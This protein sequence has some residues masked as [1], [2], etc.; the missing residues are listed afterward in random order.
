MVVLVF[1]T[2][3]LRFH[4]AYHQILRSIGLVE[5]LLLLFRTQTSCLSSEAIASTRI[6][7][8]YPTSTMKLGTINYAK[9]EY[10]AVNESNLMAFLSSH[11][12]QLPVV[13]KQDSV[14]SVLSG[15]E[16]VVL[17]D[18]LALFAEAA[19]REMSSEDEDFYTRTF[20]SVPTLECVCI[21]LTDGSFQDHAVRL[22]EMTLRVALSFKRQNTSIYNAI[23]CIMQSIRY[24]ALSIYCRGDN[25]VTLA[26]PASRKVLRVALGCLDEVVRPVQVRR[27]VLLGRDVDN[28]RLGD[29]HKSDRDQIHVALSDCGG[30]YTCLAAL[31]ALANSDATDLNEQELN[32]HDSFFAVCFIMRLIHAQIASSQLVQQAFS[33]YVTMYRVFFSQ[34]SRVNLYFLHPARTVTFGLYGDLLNRFL[35]SRFGNPSS[36]EKESRHSSECLV[37]CI[38]S[39]LSLA[40][41]DLSVETSVDFGVSA[42]E[43]PH[44]NVHTP[45]A[46][47]KIEIHHPGAFG[48]A[49]QMLSLWSPLLDFSQ[50]NLL[51]TYCVLAT[52]E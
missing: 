36:R 44:W 16:F 4:E 8:A 49:I 42:P 29:F 24:V 41:G 22:W 38:R 2:N 25:C 20:C 30:V 33:R 51:L 52:K 3:L 10:V 6:S 50:I 39:L 31:C 35:K 40:V 37:L 47:A 21:L 13:R 5:S 34:F 23:N 1:L 11:C 19:H 48:L 45:L 32:E 15:R 26:F 9:A 27:I 43:D 28:S 12:R 14:E 17:L 7:V 18:M 46:R